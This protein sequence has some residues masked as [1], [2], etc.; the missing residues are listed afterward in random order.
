MDLGIHISLHKNCHHQTVYVKFSLKVHYPPPYKREIW[1]F[2]N[3]NTDHINRAI[4]EF[5]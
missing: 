4:N 1:H 2:E 5:S 3:V